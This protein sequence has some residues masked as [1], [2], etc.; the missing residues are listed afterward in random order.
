[1]KFN[2]TQYSAPQKRE[3]EAESLYDL[4][5]ETLGA[6]YRINS[7]ANVLYG[8]LDRMV[9]TIDAVSPEGHSVSVTWVEDAPRRR[10]V[11]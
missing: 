11:A 1:M 8:K 10:L 7:S 3:V 9:R 4:L 2:V 5:E 6:D